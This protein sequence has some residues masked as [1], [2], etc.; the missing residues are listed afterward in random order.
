MEG[1]VALKVKANVLLVTAA[2]AVLSAYSIL[3]SFDVFLAPDKYFPRWFVVD[4]LLGCFMPP[5]FDPVKV[6]AAVFGAIGLLVVAPAYFLLFN[7]D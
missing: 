1:M 5:V 4:G 2:I 7:F 3:F 6:Y